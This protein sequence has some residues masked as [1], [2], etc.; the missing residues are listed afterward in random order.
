MQRTTSSNIPME[1][2]RARVDRPLSGGA[3]EVDRARRSRRNTEIS[4]TPRAMLNGMSQKSIAATT[5]GNTS[6]NHTSDDAFRASVKAPIHVVQITTGRGLLR[7]SIGAAS[8]RPDPRLTDPTPEGSSRS[9]DSQATSS[10]RPCEVGGI[11]LLIICREVANAKLRQ[12]RQLAPTAHRNSRSDPVTA[13]GWFYIG[14]WV[15]AEHV[16]EVLRSG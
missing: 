2:E 13:S 11:A 10:T 15:Q 5:E 8:M 9:T 14:G 4:A 12:L 6:K 1:S 7:P 16:P 3:D